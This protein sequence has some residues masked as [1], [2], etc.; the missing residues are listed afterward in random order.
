[1]EI[2]KITTSVSKLEKNYIFSGCIHCIGEKQKIQESESETV[3][4]NVI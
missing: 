3:S 1:M 2:F 4:E